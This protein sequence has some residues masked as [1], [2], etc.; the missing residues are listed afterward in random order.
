M[1]KP[2]GERRAV[3]YARGGALI[4]PHIA[5]Y[6]KTFL[7]KPIESYKPYNLR[8]AQLCLDCHKEPENFIRPRREVFN[9][10]WAARSDQKEHGRKLAANYHLRSTQLRD[11]SICHR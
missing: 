3:I 5:A 1:R 7:G 9:M 4:A 6:S 2:S 11:C 8:D 10:A